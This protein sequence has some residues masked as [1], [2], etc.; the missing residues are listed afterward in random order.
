MQQGSREGRGMD[1][2]V[3]D[4]DNGDHDHDHHEMQEQK[5]VKQDPWA[6]YY[7]FIINEGSFKFWAV[8]QVSF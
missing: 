8:F 6:G 7:D 4:Y 1:M 5:A 3:M 2:D